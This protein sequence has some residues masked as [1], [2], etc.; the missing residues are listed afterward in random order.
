[1]RAWTA[2]RWT[3]AAG[4]VATVLLV[5]AFGLFFAAGATTGLT[6]ANGIVN[7]LRQGSGAIETSAV[8]IFVGLSI[9][10]VFLAG[11][12]A[13]IVRADPKFDYLGTAAFGLGA[14]GAILAFVGLGIVAAA[15]ANATG[16]PDAPAVHAMFVAS[17]VIGGAPSAIALGFFL[18]VS[19]SALSKS[20]ILPRWTAW[21]SWV[22]AVLVLVTAPAVY[23]GDNAGAFYTADGLVTILATLPFYVWTL[24]VSIAI[25][26]KAP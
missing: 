3:G 26:R 15:T 13:M 12:R 1:M 6:T 8:L 9:F 11:L 17:G 24:A 21:L 16:T 14:T 20:A 23:G 18:A 25:L 4:V 10:F 7:Y 22:A 2:E 19:G 5:I